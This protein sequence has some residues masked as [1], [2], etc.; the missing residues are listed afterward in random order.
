MKKDVELFFFFLSC[1]SD[2]KYSSTKNPLF[3]SVPH[4]LIGLFGFLESN[5]FSSLNL[6]DISSL[7]DSELDKDLSSIC[8]LPFCLSVSV[9]CLTEALQFYEVP[10][11]DS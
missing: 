3:S 7:S 4:F 5:F 9:L 10:F 2:T 11:V 6:L 8:W 1:F